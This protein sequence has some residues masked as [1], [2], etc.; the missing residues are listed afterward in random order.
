MVNLLEAGPDRVEPECPHYTADRCGG[1]QLQHLAP[2]AQ[3]AA[4][5]AIVGDALRRIGRRDLP[6]PEIAPAPQA[7]RYR[8]KITLAA[9]GERVGLHRYDGPT[10]IF[11]LADCRITRE[12]LMQLWAALS[13]QRALLPADL[14]D[15]VL[16]ED[17]D[18]GLHVIV[19]GGGGEGAAG[20]P[21]HPG[22]RPPPA[23]EGP[24]RPAETTPPPGRG[25]AGPGWCGPPRPSAAVRNGS[26]VD[27]MAV[28][29]G[30]SRMSPM[31]KKMPGSTVLKIVSAR[32]ASQ[33][34]RV[35]ENVTAAG[36]PA[37]TRKQ[38]AEPAFQ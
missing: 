24:A 38:T 15:V 4:K 9:V 27:T 25:A 14:E 2:A 34:V 28:R 20:P 3:L 30:P 36:A 23:A 6:D 7:F 32:I 22:P 29:T 5:R 13:T 33:A 11:Q 17:R 12:P 26:T 21:W 18:G 35:S 19:G 10:A 37:S 16:R 31:R 8:T 1:C